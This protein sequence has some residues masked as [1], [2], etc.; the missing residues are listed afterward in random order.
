[1]P[2]GSDRN[3]PVNYVFV[4]YEN[5]HEVDQTLIG[6]QNVFVTLLIGA[7]QSKLDAGLVEKL[8]D[9]AASVQ[10]VRL[11]SSGRNALDFAIAFYLGKAANADPSATFHIVSKD[12]GFDSLIEHLESRNIHVRRHADYASLNFSALPP[13]PAAV[14]EELAACVVD[15]LR[16]H[17]NNRPKRK[18]TFVS[19]LIAIC[20]KSS[21]WTGADD[22]INHLCEAGV[23]SIGEKEAVT[24]HLP[25]Q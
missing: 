25:N 18:K 16:K 4:D 23:L 7:R 12:T 22:L 24:Y 3:L 8:I 13:T 20:G 19:L 10:L 17:I 6:S 1:M 2:P 5:V 11:N 21:S 14:S 9:H 15:H